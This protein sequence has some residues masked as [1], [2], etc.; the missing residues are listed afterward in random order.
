MQSCAMSQ[1]ALQVRWLV[2]EK[3]YMTVSVPR[4]LLPTAL[5]LPCGIALSHFCNPLGDLQLLDF[6]FLFGT[7]TV[8]VLNPHSAMLSLAISPTGK[9]KEGA[10]HFGPFRF[11]TP[12]AGRGGTGG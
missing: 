2:V 10:A 1:N 8:V 12:K 7:T 11:C 3:W 9:K 6:L 5:S 4:A